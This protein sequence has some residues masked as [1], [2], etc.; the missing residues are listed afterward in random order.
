MRPASPRAGAVTGGCTGHLGV[1]LL[2]RAAPWPTCGLAL[3]VGTP[4]KGPGKSELLEAAGDDEA[5]VWT[6][7]PLC[8]GD[9]WVWGAVLSPSWRFRAE[10]HQSVE[11]LPRSLW[12]RSSG[13]CGPA[14]ASR[15][16]LLRGQPPPERASHRRRCPAPSFG[17]VVAM[18]PSP[19]QGHPRAWCLAEDVAPA[20]RDHRGNDHVADQSRVGTGVWGVDAKKPVQLRPG[21]VTTARVMGTGPC[22][23]TRGRSR[24][25]AVMRRFAALGKLRGAQGR[26]WGGITVRAAPRLF[27][28]HVKVPVA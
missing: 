6:G 12:I 15:A 23:G 19:A 1:C 17:A 3:R 18:A 9:R 11:R 20:S 26:P 10:A 25:T 8:R 27:L 16:L 4:R 28:F 22:D 5:A 14:P 13:S 21:V 24:V 7:V 2:F